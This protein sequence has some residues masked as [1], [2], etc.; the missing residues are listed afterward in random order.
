[1]QSTAFGADYNQ[2]TTRECMNG[3]YAAYFANGS[4]CSNNSSQYCLDFNAYMMHPTMGSMYHTGYTNTTAMLYG[5]VGWHA[6][7][8]WFDTGAVNYIT[9]IDNILAQQ[10]WETASCKS[11]MAPTCPTGESCTTMD[12]C[13]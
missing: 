12:I 4:S 8:G 9:Q 13:N 10:S 3:S 7:G 2:A 11:P 5:C 6:S 1:M